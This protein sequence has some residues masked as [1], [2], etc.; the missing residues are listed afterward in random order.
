MV[1]VRAAVSPHLGGEFAAPHHARCGS[2]PGLPGG[3][4]AAAG[5]MFRVLAG[6]TVGAGPPAGQYNTGRIWRVFG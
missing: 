1:G 5:W 6:T 4:E 2:R 3:F